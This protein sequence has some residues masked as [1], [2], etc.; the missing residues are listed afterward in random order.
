[1][2]G[3]EKNRQKTGR[4]ETL[5]AVKRGNEIYPTTSNRLG[6]HCAACLAVSSVYST[7]LPPGFGPRCGLAT[8]PA[9]AGSFVNNQTEK[10]YETLNDRGLQ[11]H[12]FFFPNDRDTWNFLPCHSKS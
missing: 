5:T 11:T 12:T 3:R 4:G 1:M 10:F 2:G 6:K 8:R 7:V 9:T